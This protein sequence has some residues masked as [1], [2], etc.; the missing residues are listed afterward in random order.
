MVSPKITSTY[1]PPEDFLNWLVTLHLPFPPI[2]METIGELEAFGEN[3]FAT[4]ARTLKRID[5]PVDLLMLLNTW[6]EEGFLTPH[7]TGLCFSGQG[8]QDQRFTLIHIDQN[9]RLAL[10]LPWGTTYGAQVDTHNTIV[11][12]FKLFT[13]LLSPLPEDDLLE[14]ILTHNGLHWHRLGNFGESDGADLESL[15]KSLETIESGGLD[16]FTLNWIRV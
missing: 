14:V 5:D 11:A 10:S 13:A 15:L 6:D 4:D 3:S 7:Y 2:D 12:A 8:L 9:R 16:P 1:R